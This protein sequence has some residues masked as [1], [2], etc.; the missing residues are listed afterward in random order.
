MGE[1]FSKTAM[2]VGYP[3]NYH[4]KRPVVS[5]LFEGVTPTINLH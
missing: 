2:L 4:F 1:F 5:F 3:V